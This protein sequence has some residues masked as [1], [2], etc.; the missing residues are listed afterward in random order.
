[1][2]DEVEALDNVLGLRGLWRLL[3]GERLGHWK[4]Q[5]GAYEEFEFCR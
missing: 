5:A 1:M 3:S 4:K 2:A